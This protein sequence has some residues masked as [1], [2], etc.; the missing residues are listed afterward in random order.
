MSASV[1][2]LVSG[3]REVVKASPGTRLADIVAEVCKR[4]GLDAA[5]HSLRH[6]RGGACLD[7]TA[8]FRLSGLVNHSKL[9]LVS[10]PQLASG[11]SCR[12]GVQLPDGARLVRQF[13]RAATLVDV[14]EWCHSERDS[15]PP[16]FA[17]ADQ[18][19]VGHEAL[20]TT[21][22]RHLGVPVDG[23]VLL[24]VAE[25]QRPAGSGPA[26][27]PVFPSDAAALAPGP[28]A[29]ESNP[30]P[31]ELDTPAEAMAGDLSSEVPRSKP[32]GME[33]LETG[34]AARTFTAQTDPDLPSSA[35]AP[36]SM[37]AALASAADG[38]LDG[39]M[40]A[41]VD[42]LH[43]QKQR[44]LPAL[45]RLRA[46]IPDPHARLQAGL[47]LH[48]C[49]RRLVAHPQDAKFRR[50]RVSNS[51]FHARLGQHDGGVAALRACG[52]ELSGDGDTLE[53]NLPASSHAAVVVPP[54]PSM[55]SQPELCL[56]ESAAEMVALVFDLEHSAEQPQPPPRGAPHSEAR[57]PPP[58][59]QPGP[60][61]RAPASPGLT[62]TDRRVQML[63]AAKEAVRTDVS[64]PRELVVYRMTGRSLQAAVRAAENLPTDFYEVT[65]QDIGAGGTNF[66]SA[67]A[68]SGKT[69]EPVVQTK[70]MRELARL[71][72]LPTYPKTTIRVRVNADFLLQAHFH[73]QEPVEKLVSA[74]AGSWLQPPAGL[75]AEGLPAKL[76]VHTTPPLCLLDPSKS[77]AEQGLVPAA[78][79]HATWRD[80]VSRPLALGAELDRMRG[81]S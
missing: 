43:A 10:A 68:E 12:V 2:I 31:M 15:I 30:A 46:A 41:P 23:S 1:T 22:L 32:A 77:F 21:T 59:P 33:A 38:D 8:T 54:H 52:F 35:T 66:G 19:I 55:T 18:V 17:Y 70:A 5:V 36:G 49:L 61:R 80:Q 76:Q 63:R 75:A 7:L 48:G 60:E 3:R 79:V 26:S 81:R 37:S 44:L 51:T 42:D 4:R 14:L 29:E 11:G 45:Q 20:A 71:E 24:R 27:A 25:D 28:A 73:P 16:A 34:A 69:A 9:E 65:A 53:Y 64:V 40:S 67:A 74:L 50:L 78:L 39:R 47:T 58:P 57:R 62:L 72:R 6:E 56:L 13:P